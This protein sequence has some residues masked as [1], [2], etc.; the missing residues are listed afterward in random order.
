MKQPIQRTFEEWKAD[1]IECLMEMYAATKE[2]MVAYV[3]DTGDECW[4]E[5]FDDNLTPDDAADEERHAAA[6]MGA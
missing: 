1:L 4:R 6:W 3:R 2:E 5:M